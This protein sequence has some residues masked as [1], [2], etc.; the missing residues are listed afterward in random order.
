MTDL[1]FLQDIERRMKEQRPGAQHL[2]L[3]QREITRFG[4]AAGFV[5][6]RHRKGKDQN[7]TH[8]FIKKQLAFGYQRIINQVTEKLCPTNDPFT[9][10]TSTGRS[11]S[12]SIVAA[13]SSWLRALP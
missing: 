10:S 3:S 5:I 7:L 13:T 6:R 11:R 9:F 12:S 8:H 1:E 2:Y 4:Q